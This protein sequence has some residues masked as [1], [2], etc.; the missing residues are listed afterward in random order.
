[1]NNIIILADKK[2]VKTIGDLKNI[3]NSALR[4]SDKT[5]EI[6]FYNNQGQLRSIGVKLD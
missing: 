3:V 6:T 1:M 4:R 2:K 5:I